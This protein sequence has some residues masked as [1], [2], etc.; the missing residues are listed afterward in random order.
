MSTQ[1]PLLHWLAVALVQAV[2]GLNFCVHVPDTQPYPETQSALVEQTPVLQAVAEAQ[3]IDPPHA[4]G[5]PAAQVWRLLQV[6]LVS[7]EVLAS[8]DGVPQSDPVAG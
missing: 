4:A 8:H 7:I 1:E 5:A 6:L 2:P 3:T